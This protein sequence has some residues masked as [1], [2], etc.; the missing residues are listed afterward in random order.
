MATT[1]YIDAN[2]EKKTGVTYPKY[3]KNTDYSALQKQAEA[4]NDPDAAGYYEW[5]R[6]NKITGEGMSYKPTSKYSSYYGNVDQ[7]RAA[8]LE[9]GYISPADQAKKNGYLNTAYNQIGNSYSQQAA[10][11]KQNAANVQGY[12][13]QGFGRIDS[14]YAEQMAANDAAAKAQVE[15]PAAALERER[16]KAAAEYQKVNRQLYRDTMQEQRTLPEQLAAMGYT[17]GATETSMLRN[18]LAYEQALRDNEAERISGERDIEFQIQQ[19]AQQ[20]EIAR[21]QA[22]MALAQNR[23]SSYYNMLGQQIGAVNSYGQTMMDL[24]GTR[25]SNRLSYL[26]ALQSQ[27]NYEDEQSYTRQ[28]T[29]YQD[30]VNR[31][32]N[33]GVIPSA[34]ELAAAGMSADEAKAWRNYYTNS[35]NGG[36]GGSGS[37]GGGGR[38]SGGSYSRYSGSSGGSQETTPAE[39]KDNQTALVN[40]IRQ[41]MVNGASK[42]AVSAK[43]SSAYESGYI[44]ASAATALGVENRSRGYAG[45][46]RG[47][48]A[49]K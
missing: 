21:Q 45:A 4:A 12:L 40:G 17:G 18:R 33:T 48:A 35:F 23:D 43:I 5:Q 29:A 2:G 24:M 3:N 36:S 27:Q 8:Q 38:R 13:D 6:K 37:G 20:Q 25:D 49:V 32:S 15:I 30:M 42:D 14:S 7:G 39:A 47:E 11:A 16:E 1:S 10:L 22:A 9:K 46:A 44:N 41:M 19:A 26:N 34:A 31:I 28:H